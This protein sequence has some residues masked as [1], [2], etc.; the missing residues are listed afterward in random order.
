MS[1]DPIE[2]VVEKPIKRG[3]SVMIGMSTMS[4]IIEEHLKLE[5]GSIRIVHVA[6]PPAYQAFQFLMVA[7]DSEDERFPVLKEGEQYPPIYQQMEV[8]EEDGRMKERCIGFTKGA[9]K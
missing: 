1:K 6:Q 5:P 9:T 7:Y 2:Y 4:G 8:I 3:A